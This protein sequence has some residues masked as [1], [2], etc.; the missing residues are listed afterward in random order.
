M[1]NSQFRETLVQMIKNILRE[2][3]EEKIK[4]TYFC[5]T[6]RKNTISKFLK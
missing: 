5:N 6:N 3:N 2:V 4:A 1:K